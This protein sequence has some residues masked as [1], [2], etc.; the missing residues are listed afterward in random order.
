VSSAWRKADSDWEQPER[1]RGADAGR[2]REPTQRRRARK[3]GRWDD[4]G[5]PPAPTAELTSPPGLSVRTLEVGHWTADC[6]YFVL[7]LPTHNG[8]AALPPDFDTQRALAGQR[9]RLMHRDGEGSN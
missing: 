7:D 6:R 4:N 9:H 2:S 8:R 1:P 5:S 3:E